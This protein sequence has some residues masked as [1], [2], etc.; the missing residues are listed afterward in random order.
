MRKITLILLVLCASLVSA[1]EMENYTIKNI[2]VNTENS[3]FGVSYFGD[4]QAIFASSRKEKGAPAKVWKDNRQPFLDLY[5]GILDEDGEIN[6][7]KPFSSTLNTK[8]HE[9]NVAFTKDLKTV[10]FSRNNYL[11]KKYTASKKG[12]N[13][14]Q[15]YRATIG[16]NGEWTDIKEMPFNSK[17]YQTGHP[18]L[19]KDETKLYFTSDMPGSLGETDIFVVDI[20]DDGSYGTPQNLGSS[21]NT[22][23]KEMFPFVDENDVLYFSSDGR[24]GKGGL[25]IYKVDISDLASN[26]TPKNLGHPINSVK[27][28]FNLVFYTGK[29]EGHFSSNRDGG[30]GDDDIYYFKSP[31]KKKAKANLDCS[32]IANGVVREL[33]TNKLLPGAK[34][35][36]FNASGVLLESVFADAYATFS[37]PVDCETAYKVVG[38]KPGYEIDSATFM[39]TAELDL[40][41]NLGLNL[42]PVRGDFVTTNT[43]NRRKVMIDLDMIYFD[44]DKSYIRPDA[45]IELERVVRVM[46]RYPGINIELGSHT[47]SRA[48]DDYNWS[49]SDRRATSTR[50]WL[51]MRGISASRITGRGYGETELV[52]RCS[53]GVKCSESEH[54]LNRRTEFVVLNPEQISDEYINY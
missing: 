40:K 22:F 32:Q 17:E 36:L 38:S 24:R 47:D 50:E 39:T 29:N 19:N 35:D 41:L 2:A 13:L 52:N 37:F 12:T 51:I 15:L 43:N 25:D 8:Y 16:D 10:Y 42:N 26:A 11:K 3:D 5:E 7:A 53:N 6:N 9:S 49:L 14:I 18:A 34:V 20:N 21:V 46:N 27:D 54:Q 23:E 44:L 48:S 45:A 1:Q 28:D 33:G 31:D 30:K 4:N